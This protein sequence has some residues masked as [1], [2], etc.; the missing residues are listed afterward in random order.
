MLLS[1]EENPL[2]I[3]CH[4]QNSQKSLLWPKGL[5]LSNS[6]LTSFYAYYLFSSRSATQR[7]KD[8]TSEFLHLLPL[9]R[10]IFIQM[11][12]WFALLLLSGLCLS[13]RLSE[14]TLLPILLK[15]APFPYFI[16]LYTF[17]Y[18][19]HQCEICVRSDV[20]WFASFICSDSKMFWHK[21]DLE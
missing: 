7:L 1:S 11:C 10:M 5:T 21:V 19:R 18:Y 16:F 6:G 4:T 14:K 17:V 2:V 8:S 15:V 9:S 20:V 12:T 3:F 13:I